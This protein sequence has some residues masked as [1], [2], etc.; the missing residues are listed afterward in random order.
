ML[1]NYRKTINIFG[2][3]EI[4]GKQAATFNGAIGTNG[5]YNVMKS[6]QDVQLYNE[7]KQQCDADYT[8]FEQ[9]VQEEAGKE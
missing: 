9:R 3:C 2:A 8:E 6:V 7:N 4:D 1:S 5:T